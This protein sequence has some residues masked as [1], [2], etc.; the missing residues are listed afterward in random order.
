MAAHAQAPAQPGADGL[1]R[2]TLWPHQQAAFHDA[3]GEP[4]FM[5]AIGMGGGK[6]AATI[7]ILEHDYRQAR[8]TQYGQ[9]LNTRINQPWTPFRALVLAPKSV[10]GVWPD[11]LQEHAVSPWLT[12]SGQV[13]GAHGRAL[14][15]PSVARRAEALVHA[16]QD[17]IKLRRPF[18]AVV[19]YEAAHTGD[20]RKLLEGTPWDAIILDESHRIK[21]PSGKASK[22]AE[23]LGHKTRA[24]GGRVLA[25]TGTPM[26]HS[27]L[28][29][30]AQIRALD[31]GRRLGTSYHQF[32]Q[33][34]GAGEQVW[35]SGPGGPVQRT[36]YKGL[37][38]DKLD[39][40]TRLVGPLMHQVT[41][42]E[43]DTRLGLPDTI[44]LHRHTD[45]DPSTKRVYD[46]LEKDLIARVGNGVVTAANAMVLVLRLAQ[47][48]SGYGKDAETG[49]EIQLSD[50]ALPEKGRLLAD[51][52][53]DLPV[54]EPVVVF[55][56]FHHDLNTVRRVA[57]TQGRVYGELSGR[58]RGGLT[59]AGRMSETIDVLG[60]QIQSGGVGI[61]LTRARIGVYYTLGF[62]LANYLQSRKR[63]HRPGQTRTTTYIHLLASG[64]VEHAIYG[65][66]RQRREVVD[67]V[68]AHLNGAR[69]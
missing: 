3:A 60:V 38:P 66:L 14:K 41:E 36:V 67:T 53:E 6:T 46:E 33:R 65:A 62:E 49:Q 37:R 64:T 47:A 40:F 18:M 2:H 28:D 31:G 55:C 42:A 34:Y 68:L 35:T 26:P 17:A 48:A 61:D 20:L 44:D 16:T 21:S 25:L 58:D 15:N 8:Q 32:C 54:R 69:S 19:N 30:F 43:L 56:R 10:V 23:R 63:L 5:L 51:T 1:T 4:G 52:L 39:Q 27:P 24:R 12:W 22:V 50:G 9:P 59:D 57:E 7:A 13:N 45:L 29:L 11:Q